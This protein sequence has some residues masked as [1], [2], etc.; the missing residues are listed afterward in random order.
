MRPSPEDEQGVPGRSEQGGS[1]WGWLLPDFERAWQLTLA[2]TFLGVFWVLAPLSSRTPEPYLLPWLLGGTILLPCWACASVITVR[3][4]RGRGRGV[5]SFIR[6]NPQL[7][8][9]ALYLAVALRDVRQIPMCDNGA[10]FRMILNAVQ[11][12][13]FAPA[14]SL[15]AMALA[16][17]PAQ[18]YAAYMM[19]GQF[20][21]F[22]D[23]TLANLQ[24]QLLHVAEILAFAGIAVVLF[25]GEGRKWERLLAVA[26]FAFT[27]L[28]YGMSLTV[29]PDVA[30]LAFFCL[31]FW[32][33]VR[34]YAVLAV[35]FGLLLCFSKELGAILYAGLVAGIFGLYV[36]RNANFA[37][38][39]R[40]ELPAAGWKENLPLLIPLGL[41]GLYIA[42]GGSLWRLDSAQEA[43]SLFTRPPDPWVVW[44]KTIQLFLANFNW[45]VWW[46]IVASVP[47]SSLWRRKGV[48]SAN[49]S[50]SADW[51][52]VLV[53]AIVPFLL[54]NYAYRTW[55][56]PRYLMP[57]CMVAILFLV[58]ALASWVRPVSVRM[59]ALTAILVLFGISCFRT[60][61][62]VLV[63]AYPTF[64]L[65]EH[66]MSF[67]NSVATVCDLTFY[68]REYV[69]YN[70]LFERFLAAAGYRA[71]ADELVFFIGGTSTELA[72]HNLE[73]LWT[74][75]DL[76]GPMYLE[77]GT[78]K[79]TFDSAGNL[80]LRSTIFVQSRSSPSVLPAHAFSLRP[81][82]IG[83]LGEI[84]DA[85]MK[86][87]YRVL[88]EI[89]VEEDGYSLVGYELAR[90]E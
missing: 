29:S 66:R 52:A 48:S 81:F 38:A 78:V 24:M 86:A 65:G 70:R 69:Y 3:G 18:A 23:Y 45:V 56:N 1:H 16:G 20:L 13:N 2:L 25:P 21:H 27:P 68:N 4:L 37:G 33:V 40:R 80:R 47:L 11:Q 46:L 89:L 71:D 36:L 67:Y 79:R 44:D 60:I 61:D 34:R 49:R 87:H 90:K 22:G 84:A 7:G 15:K 41:Y 75:G 88:R 59:G 10:Y 26:L 50:P 77:P 55:S 42:L 85:E 19:L 12:F 58:R 8:I 83:Q 28:V 64:R 57:A 82:W 9:A 76:L 32:A 6:D 63:R 17:H 62:P 72:N 43:V 54:A 51:F 53:V 31:G 5:W 14:G 39:S 73:Y 35:A 74:G 30:V